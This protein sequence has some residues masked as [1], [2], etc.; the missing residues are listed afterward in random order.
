[1]NAAYNI[2]YIFY[3]Q[4]LSRPEFLL[5]LVTMLGYLLLRKPA[6]VVI[7]GTIKTIVGFMLLQVGSGV[8]VSTFKPIVAKL[9]EVYSLTGTVSDPYA[10]MVATMDAL[11]NNYAWVGYTVLFALLLNV[12]LVLA[13][14]VTG[15]RTVFLTGHIMFQ[16]A[17]IIVVFFVLQMHTGMLMTVA[18][19][20]VITALYWAIGSNMIYKMTDEITEGGGFSIGHQ[21][22]YASWVAAK[23]ARYLGNREDSVENLKLPGWLSV[24]QDNI[25]ATAII[26]T[27]FFGGI[28]L[29]LGIP[30]VEA[31]AGKTHWTLFIVQTGM[32]FAVAIVA[33][34][35]GVRMFVAELTESFAGISMKLVPGAVLAI[36]CAALFSFSPNA[37]VWGFLWGAFGQLAAVGALLLVGSPIMIIP[38]FIPLFFSNATIGVYANHFG[39]WKAAAKLCFIAGV[40]E[41]VG[42]VWAVQLSGLTM[43]QLGMGD[44]STIWPMFMQGMHTG[45][46]F[47]GLT[48]VLAAVYMFFAGRTLRR[49]EDEAAR[50]EKQEADIQLAGQNA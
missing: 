19:A 7:K 22:Q 45:W 14:R 37:V 2:F 12:L 6:D 48:L 49:E 17:G 36:D 4:V 42:S 5:G 47:F 46:W 34:V 15:I 29:S 28:L 24:F 38:G 10:A 18:C 40:I 25:V 23:C 27:V 41:I 1:M 20:S 26:M 35:Q 39:G 32:T 3:S 50:L 30:N 21:Q 9:S 33:I 8:L 31:M 13:R 11:G 44:W 16:E 43:G